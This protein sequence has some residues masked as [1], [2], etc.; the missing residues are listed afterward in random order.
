MTKKVEKLYRYESWRTSV[1]IDAEMEI[2][3]TSG[4]QIKLVEYKVHSETPKGY[5]FGWGGGKHFWT[6]KV[7]VRRK[8]YPTKEEALKSYMC[9]KRKYLE[10]SRRAL[11]RA[12]E[13]VRIGKLECEKLKELK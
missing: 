3:G 7:A 9:R 4:A 2:F 11:K 10:H 8:A 1:T 6:S 5:W 12:E 13:D